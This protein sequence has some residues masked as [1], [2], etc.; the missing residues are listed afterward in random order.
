MHQQTYHG[1]SSGSLSIWPIYP[2]PPET[3]PPQHAKPEFIEQPKASLQNGNVQSEPTVLGPYTLQGIKPT[4]QFARD[5]QDKS[6]RILRSPITSS[7]FI[8]SMHG[9]IDY[10]QLDGTTVR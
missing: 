5:S 1:F 2:E 4:V 10:F 3:E 9:C 8:V 6:R 7:Y